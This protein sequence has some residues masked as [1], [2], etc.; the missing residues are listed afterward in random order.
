MFP[1]DIESQR[2]HLAESIMNT[3]AKSSEK[4]IGIL[5]LNT[6]FPRL[7]GDIGNP[8]S[9]DFP[10]HYLTV[11][12]AIPANIT[13]A[14]CLPLSL[15]KKFITAAKTLIENNVSVITT[16]CGFLSTMQP[17]LARLSTIPVICSALELLPLLAAIHGGANRV[18]VLTFNK[19]TLNGIH[20]AGITPAAIEGLLP[21]DSLRKVII[22][23]RTSVD[24]QQALE[25]V[26][27]ACNRL[28]KT[29]PRISAILF[30]CTNLSPYK[31]H[32]RA[33]TGMPVYDVIDAVH[34]L[35]GA[36]PRH[37]PEL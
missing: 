24:E 34:W 13:V 19:E 31:D 9:F 11:K 2:L 23:D 16:T 20:T 3:S 27:A 35:L 29:A 5:K 15:Q 21:D 6:H 33:T 22:E 10:V 28:L 26:M 14:S 30:E 17:Q 25:C 1:A 37:H 12:T 18:G 4:I 36:Q 7:H 8:D 32:I